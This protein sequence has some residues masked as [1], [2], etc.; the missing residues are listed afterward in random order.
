MVNFQ[1]F[2]K[3]NTREDHFNLHKIFG[4]ITLLHLIIR[5]SFWIIDG[6]M[7]LD[8]INA[9]SHYKWLTPISLIPHIF[10]S[11]SSLL[12]H[13]PENRNYSYATIYP[14][15]RLH[16]IFFA[17]RSIIIVFLFWLGKDYLYY[18]RCLVVLLTMLCADLATYFYSDKNYK[19][20]TREMPN[21]LP[22]NIFIKYFYAI[23]QV[24]GTMH[25][26][27]STKVDQVF[28]IL[29][30]IQVAAL[31][32]T[33]NKKNIISTA[34][35]NLYYIILL[36][37]NFLYSKTNILP[38]LGNLDG[39]QKHTITILFCILRFKYN[40]NKYLLWSIVFCI[41]FLIY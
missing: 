9:N 24:I 29:I 14:E 6:Y 35:V 26:I 16:S 1:N 33:L 32:K 21:P 34:E 7:H 13:L 23:S 40:I 17:M 37:S 19:T 2:Y 3:L 11:L 31:L 27:F 41:Y 4:S 10:L 22:Q 20:T 15:F 36:L 39:Y 30:P 12:F 5:C 38:E 28:I 8:N 25:C 18:F